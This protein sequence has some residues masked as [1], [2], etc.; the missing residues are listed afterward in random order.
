LALSEEEL[1]KLLL[2]DSYKRVTQAYNVYYDKGPRPKSKKGGW[3]P[4]IDYKAPVGTKVYSPVS[5]KVCIALIKMD[6]GAFLLI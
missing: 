2:K 4:G 6:M 1:G 3:H 5:G